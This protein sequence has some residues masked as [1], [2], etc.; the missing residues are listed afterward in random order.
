MAQRQS[1]SSQIT[2]QQTL[3]TTLWSPHERRPKQ[4]THWWTIE[5]SEPYGYLVKEA[6]VDKS[7]RLQWPTSLL[8]SSFSYVCW[9]DGWPYRLRWRRA[10]CGWKRVSERT[11]H[12]RKR[13][14]VGIVAPLAWE[15]V[16]KTGWDL[17]RC[18]IEK[19][20]KYVRLGP[21]SWGLCC[22]VNL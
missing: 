5:Q 19:L 11:E 1:T 6:S 2:W 10:V 8:P 13:A 12:R 22:L 9:F 20:S 18:Q 14:P 15:S 17:P 4:A 3:T 21:G 16:V 7:Q